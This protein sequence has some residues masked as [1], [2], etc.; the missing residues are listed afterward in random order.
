[1]SNTPAPTSRPEFRRSA[2]A[3]RG[4]SGP[5]RV[6]DV[7]VLA[8]VL[9]LATSAALAEG[10]IDGRIT[11]ADGSPVAGVAVV[12]GETGAA[13]VT[14]RNGSFSFAD[15]PAG[16]YNLMFALGENR[17]VEEGVEVRDGATTSVET[18]VDWEI[19]FAE[20]IT[21]FSASR[22]EER[23]VEAPAAVTIVTEDEIA[24]EA[25]HG[26]VPK[27]LE[28]TPGAEVTQSGLYDYN[29]NTRGFNSSL[30][31]RVA[32]L[33][34]GRNVA[35]PFLGAQE[36]AA[37]SFPLDDLASAE[38]VRGPSA[39][40][41]GANASSGVLNLVT[42]QPKFSEGGSLRLAG[43]E[44]GTFN[45]D[46][47]WATELSGGWYFKVTGGLRQS[48]DF[49]RSRNT[50]VEYSVP[51]TMSGQTDCLPVEAAPLAVVDDNDITF[52]TARFDKYFDNGS[53][54]TFEGGTA[55]IQG[56]VFQT[57]IGRVQVVDVERPWARVNYS[58]DHWNFLVDYTARDAPEQLAL[59]SGQNLA[60]D[61]E[62]IHAEVQTRW[63]LA[64][65][66]GR[67][68]AGLSA[69]EEDI[70]SADPVTGRQTLIFAPVDA[71][72]Q[73]LFG[74]FDWDFTE[75]V[76]LV[77]A[78]R[79]DD[80][81][82]HDSQ[83]SPKASVVWSLDPSHS[84]RFT[85]NEAFQVANYSEFFLQANV[86]IPGVGTS[87]DLS[88][89]EAAI[90]APF[91]VS[92]GFGTPT[93]IL[94]VGNESLEV[95]EI[96]TFEVGYSGILAS[97]AFLTVDYY[98]SQNENFITDL[99]PQIDA[100]TGMRT[101]PN[102]GAYQA[103]SA[104]PAPV[105]S[106][107]LMTLQGAL[108]PLFP[109]LS[110]NLDGAPI[111]TAVSYRNF[112]D[113]DTQGVDVGLNYYFRPD[114]NLAATYSWFDFDINDRNFS[115]VEQLQPNTPENKAAV[116]V[117]YDNGTFDARVDARWVDD[118]RWV[119]GPFQGD[120]DSYTSV[121]LNANYRFDE[122]WSVGIAVANLLDDE[123]NQSFGGDLLGRRALGH[124]TLAW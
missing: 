16:T 99:I 78:A 39:A 21:V 100:S 12:I 82:L 31:R 36:W 30:N 43:G 13:E 26:Q 1:M 19:A 80:S 101:N 34:D 52:G 75:A 14:D 86:S 71:D 25:A 3:I 63:D 59:A 15:V 29:F 35:L 33:I 118:F 91:S 112:G 44:L 37:V 10:R 50:M 90:C 97:K 114:W 84:L 41:Y 58:T 64:G 88:G 7:V 2:R 47:R 48:D 69:Q 115:F 66:R 42:R 77:V 110:H 49:T 76:K 113:V 32:T 81:S 87:V 5:R 23:I 111:F 67:I 9:L 73:A 11:R 121:D 83:F 108:G 4:K 120:I 68:V 95:E 93:P 102:F 45:A 62:R 28:F 27:L 96:R 92:C 38:L 124:V 17:L 74:Q 116:G 24:Q 89:V 46:V 53:V 60:L 105:Q 54:L 61:T 40:L 79:F 117:G 107:L 8:T 22:R 20:T 56:P 55:D 6:L 57:G 65:G 70:D 51:C 106:T 98:T 94:A 72:A 122:R 123:H 119:V 103:P 109:L 104:L 85:Y 18:S